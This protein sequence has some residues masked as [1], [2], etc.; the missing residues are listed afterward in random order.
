VTFD[1]LVRVFFPEDSER[2]GA[3]AGGRRLVHYATAEAAYKI[4]A[5]KQV[6]LR[7][8]LL[9]N[10]FSEIEHGLNCLQAAWVSSSG[11]RLQKWLDGAAP[12]LREQ[13][14]STFDAHAYGLKVATFVMSLSG[15]SVIRTCMRHFRGKRTFPI[16]M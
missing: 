6:W 2:R 3:L 7:N 15:E 12:G 8:A 13:L 5:N 1:E 14:V 10:D 11:V 4:I 16:L 9:M